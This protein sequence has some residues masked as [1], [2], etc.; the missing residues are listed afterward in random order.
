MIHQRGNNQIQ[1]SPTENGFIVVI[2]V[3]Y[4][5]PKRRHRLNVEAGRDPVLD[6]LQEEEPEEV[7][8]EPFRFQVSAGV[9]V[10]TSYEGVLKFLTGLKDSETV[11]GSGESGEAMAFDPGEYFD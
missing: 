6:K 2:P 7:K 8:A 9:Y 10:F 11:R 1:I 4:K 3:Y 5:R